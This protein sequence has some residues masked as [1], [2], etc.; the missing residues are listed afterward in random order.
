MNECVVIIAELKYQQVA[1]DESQSTSEYQSLSGNDNEPGSRDH[2]ADILP[3]IVRDA[4]EY[5]SGRG[6]PDVGRDVEASWSKEA[7]SSARGTDDETEDARDYWN[8]ND[9]DRGGDDVIALITPEFDGDS[10][11]SLRSSLGVISS[12]DDALSKGWSSVTEAID[13]SDTEQPLKTISEIADGLE[14]TDEKELVDWKHDLVTEQGAEMTAEVQED[15][16]NEEISGRT[17]DGNSAE[18]TLE[19]CGMVEA[20]EHHQSARNITSDDVLAADFKMS[21]TAQTP[22]T[23]M[24]LAEHRSCTAGLTAT[25]EEALKE[26]D[27]YLSSVEIADYHQ[28]LDDG[29]PQGIAANDAAGNDDVVASFASKYVE[30]VINTG[31]LL[32]QNITT[33]DESK[34]EDYTADFKKNETAEISSTEMLPGEQM[35]PTGQSSC[36]ID[37]TVTE[38]EALQE[39]NAYLSS[40]EIADDQLNLVVGNTFTGSKDKEYEH[41]VLSDCHPEVPTMEMVGSDVEM[42]DAEVDAILSGSPDDQDVCQV[43]CVEV[44]PTEMDSCIQSSEETSST[45]NLMG[46]GIASLQKSCEELDLSPEDRLELANKNGKSDISENGTRESDGFHM[47]CAFTPETSDTKHQFETTERLADVDGT[48]MGQDTQVE[49]ASTD[50]LPQSQLEINN[51]YIIDEPEEES[52]QNSSDVEMVLPAEGFHEV[53]DEDDLEAAN[54]KSKTV[55]DDQITT[56]VY[57][58]SPGSSLS[59]RRCPSTVCE[60]EENTNYMYMESEYVPSFRGVT[61]SQIFA[62]RKFCVDRANATIVST[63]L[64]VGNSEKMESTVQSESEDEDDDYASYPYEDAIDELPTEKLN[65]DI[66]H[67]S[68]MSP[69][70][71][72]SEFSDSYFAVEG[73]DLNTTR[74]ERW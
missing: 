61:A 19:S 23:E 6:S 39:V 65:L 25:E 60:P 43:R 53:L 7:V 56:P 69:E 1:F 54:V 45:S 32:A 3:D 72:Y 35:P 36:A 59:W 57:I 15:V 58:S 2:A 30:Y 48:G 44:D 16:D 42:A 10:D 8:S 22:G 24:P 47:L 46:S 34:D 40:V 11:V 63:G 12:V 71:Q 51:N 55:E 66:L 49:P 67:K 28:N 62:Y 41:A 26:L 68:N 21:K 13:L 27:A 52:D 29:I 9:K 38:E 50:H 4:E 31:S 20:A 17:V 37:L 33:S 64:A 74:L 18:E 14:P 5:L 73:G 70:G